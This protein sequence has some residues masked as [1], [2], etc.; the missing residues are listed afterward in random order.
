MED[1][2]TRDLSSASKLILVP[3]CSHEG[4]SRPNI[5]G[6]V[7]QAYFLTYM[8]KPEFTRVDKESSRKYFILP[9]RISNKAGSNVSF[10]DVRDSLE[11]S[12][13]LVSRREIR[14][15][16]VG[17]REITAAVLYI[18]L[19]AFEISLRYDRV[20][21]LALAEPRA[22]CTYAAS[23][24]MGTK[25]GIEPAQQGSSAKAACEARHC[26]LRRD[27]GVIVIGGE[28]I[29]LRIWVKCV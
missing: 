22:T 5:A 3:M 10:E 11:N 16:N 23:V 18:N 26:G 21:H 14:S 27:K 2:R 29:E 25:G 19:H 20:F 1:F 28:R 4:P 7:E 6:I 12:L 17:T 13:F 15:W 24:K 8:N 9:S